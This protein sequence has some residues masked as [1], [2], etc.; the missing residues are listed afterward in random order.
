LIYLDNGATSFPKPRAVKA[1]VGYALTHLGNPGRGGYSAA[2]EADRRVF[3]TREVAGELLGCKPEQVV[4]TPGCTAALNMA[5]RSLVKPGGRVQITGFEHNAVTRPLHHLDARVQV[6]GRKLF[7]WQNTLEEWEAGLKTLPEAAVFTCAS[8]VFG[9]RLPIEEMAALCRIYR[10]PFIIDAAQGAGTMPLSLEGLGA[11]YMAVPGH[12][13]LLGPQGVGMLLCREVPEPILF[14]GTGNQPLSPD[15]PLELPE[16]GEAGTQNIPGISGLCAGMELVK[17]LD[18]ERIGKREAEA[19]YFCAK[20]LRELGY[21]VF[22]GPHQGGTVSFL[23]ETDCEEFARELARRG[24]AV[25]AGLH[26]APLAHQSAGT[27]ETG[28]VRVSFGYR[29]APVQWKAFLDVAGGLKGKK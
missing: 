20:G 21:R 16:R 24:I 14:G 27:E 26:C 12:K 23:P 10:V 3:R 2:L 7:D 17:A 8:N 13:G 22:S 19:A 11:A 6:A 4:F 28:T 9:Y 5:I 29:T 15:M 1:A 25:R 18:P